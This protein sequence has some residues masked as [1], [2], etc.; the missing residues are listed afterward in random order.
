MALGELAFDLLERP[1]KP[2]ERV[3]GNADAG[4]GDAEDDV[5]VRRAPAHR[6]AAAGRRELH[7]VR[8]EI[9]RD[10]LD[11]AAVG[12]QSEIGGDARGH[13]EPLFLCL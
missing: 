5:V 3:A 9:K 7:S 8:Q 11:G 13:F 4:V 1:A 2:R 6:D 12:A 10:L